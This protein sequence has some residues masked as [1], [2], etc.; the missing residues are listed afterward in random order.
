M[1]C[2]VADEPVVVNKSRPEKPGNR[3]EEKTAMTSSLVSASDRLPKASNTAK[4]G[5]FKEVILGEKS[6]NMQHQ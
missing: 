3:V 2:E 6:I 4:G 1:R 5:S